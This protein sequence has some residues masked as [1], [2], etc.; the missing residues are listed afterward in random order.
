MKI[1][2]N[3]VEFRAFGIPM[4]GNLDNGY[5]IGLTDKGYEICHA[6]LNGD[7]AK[8]DIEAVDKRLLFHLE[9]GGF[10]RPSDALRKMQAA[11]L[12]VTQRCNLDCVGCYSLNDDRNKSEDLTLEEVNNCIDFLH[13]LGIK[14]LTISGGEPFLRDDLPEIIRYAKR[15]AEIDYVEILS[16]GTLVNDSVLK[17][18]RGDIDRIAISFDGVSADD[19]AFIRKRQRFTELSEAVSLIKR[20]GINAHIIP[21]VY[22]SNIDKIGAYKDFATSIGATIS[23]SLFSPVGEGEDVRKCTLS[24]DDLS[25]LS[26][27]LLEQKDRTTT[28]IEDTTLNTNL[29]V[30]AGCGAGC[31]Q[32]SISS[33]GDVYPCHMLQCEELKMGNALNH[34]FEEI[35]FDCD[36]F[37]I[38]VEDI[39]KCA[40]CDIRYLCG[41]GCRARS[42]RNSGS[43]YSKDPYCELMKT[44]YAQIFTRLTNKQY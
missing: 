3:A 11:Y 4:L 6:L 21:T 15:V 16:N 41:G 43:L 44:Y 28:L 31:S 13:S 35:D 17:T 30:T 19:V 12:H 14:R 33:T 29:A 26:I 37:P 42:F 1:K 18:M 8:E 2:A 7:V 25:R 10:F 24:D 34:A 27:E 9:H 38:M 39:A 23:F 40:S 22:V 36:I 32:I 20:N 5:V